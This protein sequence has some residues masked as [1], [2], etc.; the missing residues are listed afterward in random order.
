MGMHMTQS[1]QRCIVREKLFMSAY[2]GLAAMCQLQTAMVIEIE[3]CM[4][5]SS[6]Y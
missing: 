1:A 3:K 2:E 5:Q 4:L 6:Y